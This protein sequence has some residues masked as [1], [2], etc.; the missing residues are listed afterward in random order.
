M[1]STCLSRR[2]MIRER[3]MIS[4]RVPI[5]V[6]TFIQRTPMERLHDPT[7]GTPNSR[8][9]ASKCYRNALGLRASDRHPDSL[10]DQ[11]SQPSW[12]L[13]DPRRSVYWGSD[14]LPTK[15]GRNIG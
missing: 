1:C 2:A 7:L 10:V 4:G 15:R 8:V 6:A 9:A 13:L 12:T 11:L 3:R 5:T 14:G